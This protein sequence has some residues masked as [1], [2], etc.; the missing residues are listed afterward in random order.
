VRVAQ[1]SVGRLQVLYDADCG[2]CSR[3]A[4]LLRRLDRAGRLELI[5]LKSAAA[6]ALPGAPPDDRLLERMH[7]RDASGHWSIGGA[8]WLRIADA[9]PALGPLAFLARLPVVHRF[10]GPAYALIARNR[11]RISRLLGDD[12]CAKPA[13]RQ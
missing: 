10:V 2:F 9:V 8:G 1:G 11:H 6:A 12:A 7:V 13:S 3:S 5:P 4:G